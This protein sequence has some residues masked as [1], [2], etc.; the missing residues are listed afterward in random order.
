MCGNERYE[1]TDD[2]NGEENENEVHRRHSNWVV[3]NDITSSVAKG[4]EVE[5]LL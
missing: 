3:A 2:E 5:S 1:Q 4:D